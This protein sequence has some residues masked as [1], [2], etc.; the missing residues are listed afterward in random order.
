MLAPSCEV[1]FLVVSVPEVYPSTP[2]PQEV[3]AP[4]PLRPLQHDA[5]PGR[6]GWI[7]GARHV[8]HGGALAF[9]HRCKLC[10]YELEDF[11]IRR[12]PPSQFVLAYLWELAHQ[13]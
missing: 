5:R 11:V 8:R 10:S 7:P 4:A 3:I 9:D 13:A 12:R 2:S 6:P 1:E